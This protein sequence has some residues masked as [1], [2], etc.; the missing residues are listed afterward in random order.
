MEKK[1][2]NMFGM[3]TKA[4]V[5]HP[6]E[7]TRGEM[8]QARKAMLNNNAEDL[9]SKAIRIALD[10]EHPGQVSMMNKLLDRILPASEFEKMQGAK[11]AIQINISGI[12]SVSVGGDVIEGDNG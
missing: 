6:A 11:T 2:E 3:P 5:L 7:A 4:N 1:K 9:L 10:D 8:M 12:D